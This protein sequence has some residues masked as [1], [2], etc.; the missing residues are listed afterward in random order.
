M[1]VKA[2]VAAKSIFAAS[3][4]HLHSL[5]A[6]KASQSL[7]SFLQRQ[8]TLSEQQATRIT[9][10]VQDS[11]A[12]QDA[13]AIETFQSLRAFLKHQNTLSNR[14]IVKIID[15][16]QMS[17]T[18]K[19]WQVEST[20]SGQAILDWPHAGSVNGRHRVQE[21]TR[22]Q[23][24]HLGPTE[25]TRRPDQIVLPTSHD[26][27]VASND[28]IDRRLHECLA[29]YRSRKLKA[30]QQHKGDGDHRRVARASKTPPS[31]CRISDAEMQPRFD[32]GP[33]SQSCQQWIKDLPSA[34]EQSS[35]AR[36]H[37]AH[38]AKGEEAAFDDLDDP[39]E[40]THQA[41]IHQQDMTVPTADK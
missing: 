3:R 6:S 31:P 18:D 11:L 41:T 12:E 13:T 39:H 29:I 15:S 2:L 14:Q 36:T 30:E 35:A 23:E 24:A 40:A 38:P 26:Y 8:N 27:K 37:A 19:T 22:L 5:S 28:L 17:P 21:N 9:E 1:R 7:Q 33:T 25:L 20:F 4:Q 32:A 16:I 34:L 10:S